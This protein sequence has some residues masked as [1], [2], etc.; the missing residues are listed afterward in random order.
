MAGHVATQQR[1]RTKLSEPQ[2]SALGQKTQAGKFA[3]ASPFSRLQRSVGNQAL[4]R[5]L[6]TAAIKPRVAVSHPHDEY[7]READSVAEHVMRMPEPSLEPSLVVHRRPYNYQEK[8]FRQ[9]RDPET[10]AD[11]EIGNLLTAEPVVVQRTAA[12]NELPEPGDDTLEH[13]LSALPGQGYPLSSGERHFMESR[14]GYDFQSVRIHTGSSSAELAQALNARAFTVGNSIVFGSGEYQPHTVTGRNLLAHE[15]THVIQQSAAEPRKIQRQPRP[16]SNSISEAEENRLSLTTPGLATIQPAPPALS[17]FNFGHDRHQPKEFHR[18]VLRELARFVL[19]EF[20][21][22]F[23]FRVVGHASSPGSPEHNQALSQRR[24]NAVAA[25]LRGQGVQQVSVFA[26]G[27]SDPVASNDTVTGRT[28]NRRVD[29]HLSALPIPQPPQ[30]QPPGPQPPGP[31]PPEPQPPEPQRDFCE[32]YPILC[33]ILPIPIPFLP[34]LICLIAPELCALIACLINPSAC[35]PPIPP[36]PPTPPQPPNPPDPPPIVTFG[37]IRAA[38]TPSAM[39]D[40]I[41]DTG[42]TLVGVVVL[43]LRP[44]HGP[45]E[46]RGVGISPINGDFQ[47]NGGPATTITGST[48]LDIAG[49]RQTSSAAGAFN[50]HLEAVLG[51][52]R[53]A[54]SEPFAVSDIMENMRTRKEGEVVD[55]TGATLEVRMSWDSDGLLGLPSLSEMEYGEN[56][57]ILL[58]DGGM[59]GLGLGRHGFLAMAS[60]E[61]IDRHGTPVRFMQTEGRQELLQVHTLVDYRTGSTGENITVTNSGFGINR[62]VEPDPTRNGCLRFVVTKFGRSGTADRFTS[63]AGAGMAQMIVPLPCGGGGGGGGSGDGGGGTT[64]STPTIPTPHVGPLPSGSTPVSLAGGVPCNA[65]PGQII[66]LRIAFRAR[67]TDGRTQRLFTTTIPCRVDDTTSSQ[68]FLITLNPVPLNVAPR[69]FGPVVVT[70]RRRFIVPKR[71]IC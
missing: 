26:S 43:G 8:V 49:M 57:E 32:R 47:I 35:L 1:T 14:F 20:R 27:E 22:P 28:R 69:G 44:S 6:R 31:Q 37:R 36:T 60:Q 4:R 7:E 17:L 70:P 30:P 11:Q 2:R 68:V 42:S 51:G 39:G 41:P 63:G 50:L 67:S 61:Q 46:I 38:N 18:A 15:L 25:V 23:R 9:S 62:V 48:L 5:V 33:S 34:F 71:L 59:R 58:E 64:P 21:A 10:S 40:R 54:L 3:V 16:A 53:I 66:A 52:V 19:T 12:G 56:L 65:A 13:R 55:A 29:L 24:A 45:L